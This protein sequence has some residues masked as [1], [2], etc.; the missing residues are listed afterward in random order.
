M[1]GLLDAARIMQGLDADTRARVGALSVVAETAS[2]QLDALAS[3]A[4]PSGC[5]V[6][7]AEKQFAGHGRHGRAWLSPAGASIA[8]SVARRFGGDVAALSG[9]SLVAGI[10]VAEALDRLPGAPGS[11]PASIQLKWPNDLV[12][13]GRKLGG[14]L[15]NLRPGAVGSFEAVIGVG[16]NVDLPPDVS[17]QID[18]PWCDLG[19]VGKVVCSRNALV[20]ILLNALLPA[21]EVFER[22]G[23]APFLPG[24]QRLDALAGK[25]VRILDGARLHEGISAGI[26]DAGALR[27]CD[28]EQER[29]FH[30]GEV[31]LRPA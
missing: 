29:I 13:G 22:D 3:P 14:I 5:A 7:L 8:M 28:G 24:W 25:R 18:Q 11:P 2:T 16:I 10:A 12:A 27:L 23:L 6:Y 1:S 4:P 17:A 30:G 9:L 20:S 19:Q 21:L 15:V 31:S 26:T